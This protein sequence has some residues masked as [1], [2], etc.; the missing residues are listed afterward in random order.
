MFDTKIYL[1]GHLPGPLK[2]MNDFF[3]EHNAYRLASFATEYVENAVSYIDA[4]KDTK[5]KGN[6][7]LDSGAF[8][9]WSKGTQIDINELITF[10]DSLLCDFGHVINFHLINL[11]VLPGKKGE[12]A[13]QQQ[14]EESAKQSIENFYI[15]NNKFPKKVLPVFHRGE[16]KK[17]LELFY[18]ETDYICVSPLVGTSERE[19]RAWIR[20]LDIKEGVK[21]H[22]LATTGYKMLSIFDWY[23]VDSAS[24]TMSAA[25]GGIQFLSDSSIKNIA[26]SSDSPKTKKLGGHFLTL[27]NM[28]QE[29]LLSIINDSGFDMETLSESYIARFKWNA[30]QWINYKPKKKV[31]HEEGLF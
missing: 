14:V 8:T 4:I 5:C 22:G 12:Q 7:L 21:V 18:K 29:S 27:S 28:E 2:A 9:S 11:D 6:M 31:I 25:M 24:W 26:V 17:F 20:E 23:S 30:L 19:R 16:N 3:A 10:F 1:S 13:T 15:L